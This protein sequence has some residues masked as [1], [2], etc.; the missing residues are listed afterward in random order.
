MI[1]IKGVTENNYKG[2]GFL[3]FKGFK[4]DENGKWNYNSFEDIEIIDGLG[5][6]ENGSFTVEFGHVEG[7]FKCSNVELKSLKGAP[8]SCDVFVCSRVG[9]EEIDFV[10]IAKS[11]W[12]EGN[13]ISKISYPFPE[14]VEAIRLYDNPL[15][16]FDNFP[17]EM[18]DLFIINCKFTSLEGV[19]IVRRY[20]SC[21]SNDIKS[22]KGFKSS[23]VHSFEASSCSL[24]SLEYCP[25]IADNCD[26]HDNK[27]KSL[28]G[29]KGL[30]NI[31][32]EDIRDANFSNNEDLESFEGV[33]NI[34]FGKV[35]ISDTGITTL[36]HLNKWTKGIYAY[37]AEKLVN[38]D[39]NPY[40][41]GEVSATFEAP[42]MNMHSF[43][44]AGF[45]M[46]NIKSIPRGQMLNATFID[47]LINLDGLKIE[48]VT[49]DQYFDELFKHIE[50]SSSN[51]EKVIEDLNEI[52]WYGSSK[53]LV[54]NYVNS[55]VS[56][57]KYN[58]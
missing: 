43:F 11:Y 42:I 34:A 58:L 50:N 52:T 10:P 28:K 33:E 6:I 29:L 35:N 53:D 26:F 8:T 9:L 27:L 41:K 36:E 5:L 30:R 15:S 46:D 48:D 39:F 57:I 22:L 1:D 49:E 20:F 21:S 51:R 14:K 25:I 54:N 16:S 18:E 4:Q 38:V 32:R 55:S 17:K 23:K 40:Y 45:S 2:I 12:F 7:T 47:S 56:V 13:N 37:K 19:P 44:R 24:E 3:M 31:S